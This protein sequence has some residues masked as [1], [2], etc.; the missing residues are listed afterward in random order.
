MIFWSY[1]WMAFMVA[2]DFY[3]KILILKKFTTFEKLKTGADK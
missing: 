3:H 2:V 1:G